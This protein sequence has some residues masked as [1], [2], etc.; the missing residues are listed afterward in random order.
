MGGRAQ[1]EWERERAN[2][3]QGRKGK[4]ADEG[5][6]GAVWGGGGRADASAR[7]RRGGLVSKSREGKVA[8]CREGGSL[9][10]GWHG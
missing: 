5:G 10:R 3:D 8:A 2:R 1:G 7:P 9:L 4:T 6:E